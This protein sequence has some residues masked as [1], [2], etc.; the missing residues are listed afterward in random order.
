MP[1]SYFSQFCLFFFSVH[2]YSQNNQ[3]L[4]WKKL[5]S[6]TRLPIQKYVTSYRSTLQSTSRSRAASSTRWCITYRSFLIRKMM[7]LLSCLLFFF[8]CGNETFLCGDSELKAR[9]GFWFTVTYGEVLPWWVPKLRNVGKIP[10]QS[11]R[12]LFYVYDWIWDDDLK[13]GQFNQSLFR[14]C[15]FYL[16]WDRC[17][18]S[19]NALNIQY[20]LTLM[21][22]FQVLSFSTWL[23][24]TG[25]FNNVNYLLVTPEVSFFPVFCDKGSETQLGLAA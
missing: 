5:N 22:W 3:I 25:V 8:C 21:L 10:Q 24:S 4:P 1:N 19:I 2:V 11:C 14:I 12:M 20:V 13:Y 9:K 7:H 23:L 17:D 16:P 6:M 18:Y 15:A